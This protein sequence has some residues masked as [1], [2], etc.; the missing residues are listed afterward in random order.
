MATRI[1]STLLSVAFEACGLQLKQ[2]SLPGVFSLSMP[3]LE[4]S[5]ASF[6]TSI[7]TVFSVK[8]SWLLQAELFCP[9]IEQQLGTGPVQGTGETGLGGMEIRISEELALWTAASEHPDGDK[10]QALF[11]AI[12][13]CFSC[14]IFT[15]TL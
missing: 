8:P 11:Q 3:F 5:Y 2:F 13:L 4:N 6:K 1:K 10:S 15:T 12:V 9:L 7:G 14:F